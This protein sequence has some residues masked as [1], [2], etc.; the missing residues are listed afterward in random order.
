MAAVLRRR[1]DACLY[2][3]DAQIR[4][5]RNYNY[6][7]NSTKY[8]KADLSTS[9]HAHIRVFLRQIKNFH[10]SARV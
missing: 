1:G 5:N 7:E 2:D 10:V 9:I 4:Y 3:D 8:N 6:D